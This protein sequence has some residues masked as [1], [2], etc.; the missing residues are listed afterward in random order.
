VIG[1]AEI[2]APT[3]QIRW[4]RAQLPGVR[5]NEHLRY[6]QLIA[7]CAGLKPV[8]TAIVHPCELSSLSGAVEPASAGLIVPVLV[9]PEAEI[10]TV[11]GSARINMSKFRLV[12]VPH[13]H[14]PAAEP[15][16]L[17]R[18]GEV[19]ALMKGSLHT[20]EL[21][22][23]VT[24]AETGLRTERRIS[25]VYLFDVPTYPRPLLITDAAVNILSSLADK[26]D[27]CQN[28][29]DLA[30]IIGTP[31]PKVA[32]LSAVET[33]T[34][35]LQSTLDAAALCKMADRGQI[36]GGLLDGPLAFDN[37][38]SL[39][40]ARTKGIGSAVA[41][42][43]DVLLVPNLEAGNVLA[44]QLTSFDGADAAGIVLGATL[45]IILTRRA[46]SERTRIASWAIAALFAAAGRATP[47]VAAV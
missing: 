25:H 15:V 1:T 42:Q 35:K 34:D 29:I 45:P 44:K 3:E 18:S 31:M 13:S 12:A 23:E 4:R 47:G 33:V 8:T 28:A 9:G 16:S 17:A 7:R 38:V 19:E 6:H 43:A 5:L 20:D 11:A 26:R 36:T 30:H 40:A 27:I 46:D 37:A 32:I 10:R 41:G 39:Q 14:A 24:A 22:Q 21:M 2:I